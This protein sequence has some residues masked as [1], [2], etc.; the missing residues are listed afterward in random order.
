MNAQVTPLHMASQKGD[1]HS[2][3]ELISAGVDVNIKGL[4][5]GVVRGL[6]SCVGG[7]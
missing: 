7:G 1:V 2:V 5:S 4:Y 3:N 6:E